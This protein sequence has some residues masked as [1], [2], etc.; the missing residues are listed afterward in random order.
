MRNRLL[1]IVIVCVCFFVAVSMAHASES[2]AMRAYMMTST[3]S[4]SVETPRNPVVTNYCGYSVATQP[5]SPYGHTY[6]W[7][8]ES[9]GT[10]T[11]NSSSIYE[12]Y[13][14]GSVF[15]RAHDGT[16]WSSAATAYA[17]PK[18]VPPA[19][20]TEDVSICGEG[21]ITLEAEVPAGPWAINWFWGSAF[22]HAGNAFTGQY[23]ESKT[24]TAKSA[25]NGCFS[26]GT[27]ATAS[28]L[29]LPFIDAGSDKEVCKGEKVI[30]STNSTPDV[31]GFS[32][33][34][35]E[36]LSNFNIA[37]PEATPFVTTKYTVTAMGSNGCTNTDDV[38]VSVNPGPAISLTVDEMISSLGDGTWLSACIAYTS[39]KSFTWSWLEASTIKTSNEVDLHVK[40]ETKTTYSV[41]VTDENNC[42][43]EDSV[44]IDVRDV[45]YSIKDGSWND[46]SLWSYKGGAPAN[47]IPDRNMDAIIDG[48]E[49]TLSANA[50]CGNILITDNA[51][52]YTVLK[53]N[54]NNLS[55]Y[56]FLKLNSKQDVPQVDIEVSSSGNIKC[57]E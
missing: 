33:D 34:N 47:T 29:Q 36:T 8:T 31:T 2:G 46:P 14:T 11:A 7:Q 6:Y 32:W 52:K 51:G 27:E 37:A 22:V 23:S 16:N 30:L 25:Y 13:E 3:M 26:D 44:T 55:V 19:P 56:G 39:N 42:S 12:I 43:S 57:I 21:Q 10:S 48:N 9:D 15:L 5:Y 18:Y 24:F 4:S 28:V 35:A 40:P 41:L 20:T 1:N 38:T 49:V 53:V 54:N 45:L 50:E 17:S